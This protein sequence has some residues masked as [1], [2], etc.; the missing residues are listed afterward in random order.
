MDGQI[1][2]SAGLTRISATLF[3]SL[4]SQPGLCYVRHPC[5]NLE[6]PC[7]A[8][9]V[10]PFAPPFLSHLTH[11]AAHRPRLRFEPML[12]QAGGARMG[13]AA[14]AALAVLGLFSRGAMV[15][16]SGAG[17]GLVVDVAELPS[18][19]NTPMKKYYSMAG[20]R[21]DCPPR[22]GGK[23][24]KQRVILPTIPRTG[25]TLLRTVFEQLSG[26]S[27]HQI[28]GMDK[29]W[30]D[31]AQAF[32]PP[33]GVLNNCSIARRRDDAS[34]ALVK[35][36]FPFL[37][38]SKEPDN[39][40]ISAVVL[41]VRQPLD[42]F[43]AWLR[44]NQGRAAREVN[45]SSRP[46]LLAGQ[47]RG[48]N[49]E[50]RDSTETRGIEGYVRAWAAHIYYWEAV[51]RI[52]RV[53]L[54]MI[55]YEDLCELHEPVAQLVVDFARDG[56]L[57]SPATTASWREPGPECYLA[58]LRFPA[59]RTWIVPSEAKK[60]MEEHEQLMSRFGYPST[61]AEVGELIDPF[62]T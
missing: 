15:D 50:S 44:W 23:R 53:P 4:I 27:V 42:A 14:A 41:T 30:D 18:E 6:I 33:C 5:G 59:A 48:G 62:W 19:Q 16:L 52:R 51:A 58:N 10:H 24:A 57:P 43:L 38:M 56:K 34:W 17:R 1:P 60:V 54:L 26:Q 7:F 22:P 28:W 29:N 12:V 61:W 55:R 40:C 37:P 2:R 9:G 20:T 25:N 39:D 36:H 21:A 45:S 49:G 3:S 8:V 46:P 11:S 47:I 13:L 32:V 31:T 35:T